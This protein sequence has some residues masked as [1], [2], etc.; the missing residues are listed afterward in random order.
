MTARPPEE[1]NT[2]HDEAELCALRGAVVIC[3]LAHLQLLRICGA[4]AVS[5]VHRMCS[6]DVEGGSPD[7]AIPAA[8]LTPKAHVLATV[9]LVRRGE[10]VLCVLPR[11]TVPGMLE[12]LDRHIIA[13]RVT[14]ELQDDALLG[15]YGPGIAEVPWLSGLAQ[16]GRDQI[17]DCEIAGISCIAVGDE[18]LA[19]PG[20][21]LISAAGESEGLIGELEPHAVRLGPSAY[22]IGRIE[23]G[24][25]RI[26][27]EL[28]PDRLILEAGEQRRVSLTKGCYPG[29][30][31]L[32][33]VANRGGV[34][35][36]LVGLRFAGTRPP[37]P[38]DRLI[39]AEGREVGLVTSATYSPTV[40]HGVGLGYVRREVGDL[41]GRLEVEGDASATVV[42]L[43]HV[44]R[45]GHQT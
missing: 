33:R 45:L 22:E 27:A 9:T 25:P 36:I 12:H 6:G 18:H 3:D 13:D 43:P 31:P 19:S 35:R 34:R 14:L 30:E 1:Q 11:E 38:G 4:D 5:F 41:G 44:P 21:M 16:L 28:G 40:G 39:D 17:A 7:R 26:G 42:S 15:V 29:Q 24:T 10:V 37:E 8:F 23:A 20:I 2:R 32:C